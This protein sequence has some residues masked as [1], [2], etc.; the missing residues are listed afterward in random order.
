V[1]GLAVPGALLAQGEIAGRVVADS[2][3]LPVAGAQV[4]IASLG[5]T[6]VVDT[7]GRFRMTGLPPGRHQVSVRAL[8]YHAD[9]TTIEIEFDEVVA[10]D[11]SLRQQA[12][13]LPGQQVTAVQPLT[14]K[15][16]GFMERQKAGAG[17]FI[18]RE[19]LSKAEGGM[20]VTGDV[21]ATVPGVAVKRGGSK[22]WITS[23]RIANNAGGCAF[24]VGGKLGPLMQI[25]RADWS[26]G[27]RPACYMDVYV[28][29]AMVFNSKY[30]ENG[31]FDVN[32]LRPEMI[33]GIEVFPSASQVPAQYNRSAGG[34]GVMLIWTRI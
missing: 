33:E 2:S 3:R 10:R 20:R 23:G 12:Q 9:S 26:A 7:S 18:T 25:D 31:L 21:I 11:F 29:G 19:Q 4:V 13:V 6:I 22:A 24:C 32:Q 16:A 28:D 34:C 14:G 17:R 8:G 30:P 1:V 27:A 15:M 5:R